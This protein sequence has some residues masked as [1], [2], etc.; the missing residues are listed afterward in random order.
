MKVIPKSG[1]LVS[2]S[3]ARITLLA[4]EDAMGKRGLDT[5]L[6]LAN[7]SH[8]IAAY[9][10]NNLE[11]AVD[12]SEFSMLNGA[13]EELYG[14]HGGRSLALSAGRATFKATQGMFGS[15]AGVESPL[16]AYLP[17]HEK[18]LLG[19]QGIALTFSQ[20]TDQKTVLSESP[21][22]FL[23]TIEACP[24]CYGRQSTT[25]CCHVTA[26]LLISALKWLSAGNEFRVT[27]TQCKAMG[28]E[29]CEYLIPREP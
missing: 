3:M 26:G 5:L 23:I 17:E 25:P 28:D 10:E 20:T 4:L 29:V 22:G 8:F 13:L 16:F 11:R 21:D 19:L 9:P 12:F 14:V 6:N 7:L 27:E 2:N 1:L 15:R 18:L 24:Q